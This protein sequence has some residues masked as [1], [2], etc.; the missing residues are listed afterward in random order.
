M[1]F[2][3][4]DPKTLLVVLTF[5]TSFLAFI[6]VFY[7]LTR[8]TYPGF[9]MWVYGTVTMA[10]GALLL[11]FRGVVPV[12]ISVLVGNAA[13]PMGAVYMLAGTR[14]FLNLPAAT[15]FIW[16]IPL[17]TL[18][19]L[20]FFFW[21]HISSAARGVVLSLSLTMVNL[22]TAWLLYRYTPRGSKA[23]CYFTGSMLAIASIS[24][25][26]RSLLW[27]IFIPGVDL[28]TRHASQTIY[29]LIVIFSQ[30][31]W[32]FG[33]MMMNGQ[34]MEEDLKES[35]AEVA[36][37][38]QDLTNALLEIKTLGGLLPICAN[39]KRI[40]DSEDYWH[41]V[42]SYISQH[43]EARFSH[44]ICPECAKILYPDMDIFEK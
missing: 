42:E 5:S 8:K 1:V 6:L 18:L 31:G 22:F 16:G 43:S 44:S 36:K 29:V 23:L 26:V 21:V 27:L 33:F 30:I 2:M 40:R 4:I 12:G 35:R 17:V 11:A 32:T 24:L 34:R 14:R 7:K 15:R 20:A 39:C 38:N 10:M 9:N 19:G 25:L 37:G 28:L 13:F 41:Q 3:T